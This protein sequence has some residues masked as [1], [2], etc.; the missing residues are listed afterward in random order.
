MNAIRFAIKDADCYDVNRLPEGVE[1]EKQLMMWKE[2]CRTGQFTDA[3]GVDHNIDRAFLQ[4]LVKLFWE[5]N[6]KGIEAPC[7]VG[8]THDPEAK[9]GRIV[10]L[11]LRDGRNAGEQ[12]S[13]YGI[14]EF[15]SQEAK[16]KLCHSSVSIEA[17]ETVSDGDGSN[18][19]FALEHVAFTDYP[20][21]AG[22]DQFKDVVF[23]IIKEPKMRKKRFAEDEEDDRKFSKG[24]R[25]ADDEEDK[26]TDKKF[27]K[28]RRFA[29][30]E[31]DEDKDFDEG[32]DDEDEEDEKKFSK[33]RKRCA[34]RFAENEDDEDDK[35]FDED[36]EKN[37]S[38]GKKRFSFPANSPVARLMRQNRELVIEGLSRDGKITPKQAEYM[39]KKYCSDGSIRF[40]IDNGSTVDFD[41]ACTL[42]SMNSGVDFE[43]KTGVQF[44]R[45]RNQ[46]NDNRQEDNA[47][48]TMYQQRWGGN[49]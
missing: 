31:D 27:A 12:T 49:K 9:R 39:A 13:L 4:N 33:G 23:S 34:R 41:T 44:S 29:E 10:Y 6:K 14:I 15:V 47:L 36:E 18:H 38:K 43:V 37:F 22:L 42:V 8:H 48:N 40:S 32:E 21:V 7:P 25:F 46:F 5:R 28:K 30:D 19:H 45:E 1:G 16:E 2:L 20:V 3:H 17:P 11:E 35:D 26:E 24:R